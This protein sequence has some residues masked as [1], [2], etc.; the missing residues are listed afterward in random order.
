[1]LPFQLDPDKIRQPGSGFLI[2]LKQKKWVFGF[3]G[4]FCVF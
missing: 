1:M 4:F 2:P 3:G